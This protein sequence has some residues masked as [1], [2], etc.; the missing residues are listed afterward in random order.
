[1]TLLWSAPHIRRGRRK[2]GRSRET[3][4]VFYVDIYTKKGD[5][6]VKIGSIPNNSEEEALTRQKRYPIR[7]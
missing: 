2:I 5:D 3:E 4:L 1:M 7:P 6:Y